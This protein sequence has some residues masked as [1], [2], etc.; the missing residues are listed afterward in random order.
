M[1]VCGPGWLSRY[2]DSLQAGRS[3]GSNPGGGRDFPHPSRPGQGPTQPP[4]KWVLGL[5]PGVKAAGTWRWPPITSNAEVKERVELYLYST[6]GPSWPV[7]EW[8]FLYFTLRV[9]LTKAYS[10]SSYKY[11]V[12]STKSVTSKMEIPV[13]RDCG[14]LIRNLFLS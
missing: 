7:I 12:F 5:F 10:P 8:T 11:Q 9:C 2:S 4:I 1:C 13:S 6:F 14:E 3:G